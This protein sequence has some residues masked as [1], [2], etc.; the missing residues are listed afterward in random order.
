MKKRN[1]K[2][3]FS[4]EVYGITIFEFKNNK[5]VQFHHDTQNL[6]QQWAECG[7][8]TLVTRHAI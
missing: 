1:L 3:I 4:L 8:S 6:E 7:T 2:Y 5:Y